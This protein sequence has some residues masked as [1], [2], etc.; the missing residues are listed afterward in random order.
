[1]EKIEKKIDLW[2][3]DNYDLATK[4]E[5]TRLQKDDPQQLS[6]AFYRNLEFGTG[7]LRGVMGVGTNRMNQYTVGA[8]T[9]GLAN[10]LIQQ[11][12]QE[13]IRVAIA[14]DSRNNSRFFADIAADVLSANGIQCFLFSALRSTPE[15][16]FTVRKYLCHSGIV[17]TAS[18]NPK[19]YNGYKVYW[20][21]GGQ[22][23]P[24]HDKNVIKEVEKISKLNQVHRNRNSELV[25]MIGKE[26][27]EQYIEN[28]LE[29]TLHPEALNAKNNISIVYSPLH[30]T[31]GVI[32]PDVLKRSGFHHVAVVEEQVEPDGN[33]PTTPYPNPEERSTLQLA[34][35]K[36]D[37][38]NAD[39]VMA[40][41]PDA[42]RVG[43]AVRNNDGE[44]V[45][46]NGNS[47]AALLTYYILSEKK[48]NHELTGNEFVVKTIVTTE[49]ISDIALDFNV[50]CEDVLTGF[51]Y[52]AGKIAEYEGKKQFLC[53]GEESYG[54]LIGDS[55]RDKDANV[56]C[57][58]FAEMTAMLRTEG[59]TVVDLLHQLYRDYGYYYEEQVSITKK[60]AS[61]AV[62]IRK[63]M[64]TF[65][66][67]PPKMIAS[68]Q[69]TK[70]LDY[71]Q[72]ICID[73]IADKTIKISLPSSDVLQFY[74]EDGT[75]IT[76]RP[77]GTEP[78]IKFYF[79]VK[80]KVKGSETIE[81]VERLLKTRTEKYI[82]H[83]LTSK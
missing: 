33:F 14:Y 12:D 28:I 44:M 51:K 3:E 79:S 20:Q 63:M 6:D 31:G 54:F 41:D 19:E 70:F 24:P 46:L 4:I 73:T 75:I 10:Y 37:K 1:M 78:K 47:V 57:C 50:G 43:V 49:L 65:R 7:G 77:S 29:L 42:D 61:G 48:R 35:E 72:Q 17:I 2:L 34:L 13:E 22:L 62:E 25:T 69:V 8:A 16:S 36:A 23:L 55:V 74:T 15:L 71:K 11:F 66:E 39:I 56:T 26:T 60:G 64:Q 68:S 21:D 59:K 27:D 52:I 9:Q 32:I 38:I 40:T 76:V 5:I 80:E 45:L 82:D 18:H 30:G 83:L 53:G 67:N 58:L 81:E